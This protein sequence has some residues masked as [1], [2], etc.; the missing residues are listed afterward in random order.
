MA[1]RSQ[2]YRL[3]WPLNAE[4]VAQLD[5]ML[6][7]LFDDIQNGSIT[8]DEEQFD[9][10]LE[11][12]QGGTGLTTY[13][14]GD[15]LY[16]LT[17]AIL[18][19]LTLGASGT[20]LKSNGTLPSWGQVDL[21]SNVTGDLPFSNLEQIATD[22]LVGRDTAGTGDVEALTV[23]GGLEFTGSGGVQVA[24]DGITYAKIQ[25]VSAASRLLGRGSA[26]GAGDVEEITLGTGLS[27]SGTTLNG[28]AAGETHEDGYWTF[29][30]DGDPDA[31]EIIYADGEPIMMWIPT[32]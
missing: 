19:R 27:L 5:E 20:V 11:P 25:N 24:D 26:A 7:I 21:T 2:P 28:T 1:A 10:L 13:V 8:V 12:D 22:R 17:S 4:Q 14:K 15:M 3:Q 23:G 30:T 29:L 31:T 18:A 32:P 9:G 16:A 6:Q